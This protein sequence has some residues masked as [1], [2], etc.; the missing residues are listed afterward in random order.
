M[1]DISVSDEMRRGGMRSGWCGEM[2]RDRM[3]WDR[4][5]QDGMG[6]EWGENEAGRGGAGCM[7][8]FDVF[9][10]C[11]T[12][13]HPPHRLTAYPNKTHRKHQRSSPN[14]PTKLTVFR[15]P[16]HP[17][18]R[19]RELGDHHLT[20]LRVGRPGDAPPC[21]LHQRAEECQVIRG[22]ADPKAA[23]RALRFRELPL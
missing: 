19:M 7:L 2:N 15:I 14:T 21:R 11:T 23:H 1:W 22:R 6:L 4:I 17:C 16:T 9:L 20:S 3:G 10:T 12:I 8:H 18:P 13:K 5:G